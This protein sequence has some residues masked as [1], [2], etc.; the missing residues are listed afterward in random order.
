MTPNI[1][2]GVV[3]SSTI[4]S[5][6][7]STKGDIELQGLCNSPL[8]TALDLRRLQDVSGFEVLLHVFPSHSEPAYWTTVPQEVAPQ[9]G[10]SIL[11][12]F[13]LPLPPS[14]A[15][16]SLGH[17]QKFK[18]IYCQRTR[19]TIKHDHGIQHIT[20]EKMNLNY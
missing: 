19:L 8:L 4:Y 1:I 10:G 15:C 5:H 17:C 3:A 16:K 14:L 6:T 7:Y 18:Y 20:G 2:Y 12:V 13:Q 11:S 9:D